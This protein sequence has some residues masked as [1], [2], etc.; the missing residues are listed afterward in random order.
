MKTMIRTYIDNTQ[1]KYFLSIGMRGGDDMRGGTTYH[2]AQFDINLFKC[3][4]LF[5]FNTTLFKILISW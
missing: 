4:N 2:D 1:R 3:L 5:D